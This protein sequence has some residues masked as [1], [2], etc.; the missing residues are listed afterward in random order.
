MPLDNDDIKQLI[1]ILQKGLSNDSTDDVPQDQP[2]SNNVIKNKKT[3][4]KSSSTNRFD[5]M[6]EK[7]LHKDDTEIDKLLNKFPPAARSRSSTLVEAKCRSCGKTGKISS[8]LITD[9]INRYKC[10]NCC[11]EPG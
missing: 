4:R 5:S 6:R 7:N 8:S 3:N 9:S 10:N 2:V 1:M 11:K